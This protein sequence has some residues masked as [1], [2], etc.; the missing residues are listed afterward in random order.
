MFLELLGSYYRKKY[1][2][3]FRC[4]RYP[5]V[6]TAAKPGGGTTDYVTL[7]MYD[8][9][10]KGKHECYLRSDSMMPMIHQE[11]LIKATVS[12]F[13]AYIFFLKA[14]SFYYIV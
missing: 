2:L 14:N 3:D 13:I 7:M 12:I 5:G 8:A 10:E 11:D 1:N 9:I 6:F 4:L